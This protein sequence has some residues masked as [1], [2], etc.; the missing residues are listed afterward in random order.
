MCIRDSIR[1]AYA[2]LLR[3]TASKYNTEL[4]DRYNFIKE[5]KSDTLVIDELV[6]IPRTIFVADITSDPKAMCNIFYSQYFGK[7]SITL[8]NK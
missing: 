3:G 7:N 1:T 6:N 5:S 2:D 8:K 4:I